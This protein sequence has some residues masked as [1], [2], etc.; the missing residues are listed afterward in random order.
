MGHTAIPRATLCRAFVTA[1]L[2][3]ME[4]V[5]VLEILYVTAKLRDG[6]MHDETFVICITAELRDATVRGDELEIR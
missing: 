3:T 6:A 1:K 2:G 5:E 4:G